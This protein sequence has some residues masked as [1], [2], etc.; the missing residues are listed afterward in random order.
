MSVPISACLISRTVQGKPGARELLADRAAYNKKF[1]S[2]SFWPCKHKPPCPD[3]TLGQL[4][5]LAES[6]PDLSP[7]VKDL[8]QRAGAELEGKQ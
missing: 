7:L 2:F 3:V 5:D 4:V 6:I 1:G 8:V